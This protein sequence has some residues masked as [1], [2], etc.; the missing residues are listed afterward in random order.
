MVTQYKI[1]YQLTWKK[2]LRQ[3]ETRLSCM[4]NILQ[5]SIWRTLGVQ[6]ES[7]TP[8]CHCIKTYSEQLVLN[9]PN[10]KWVG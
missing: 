6:W 2:M 8:T 4:C 3:W 10:L 5:N 7:I 9:W 1:L